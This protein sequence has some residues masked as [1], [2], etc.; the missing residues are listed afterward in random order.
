MVK[1]KV[2]VKVT[3]GFLFFNNE[4]ISPLPRKVLR[5]GW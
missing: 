4:N 5:G 2:K 1:V 3:V